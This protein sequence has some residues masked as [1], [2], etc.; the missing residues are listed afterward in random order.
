MLKKAKGG[1]GRRIGRL[2]RDARFS[3]R[4]TKIGLKIRASAI[5]PVEI[6]AV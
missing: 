4:F 5:D 2:A 6:A 3:V 1:S